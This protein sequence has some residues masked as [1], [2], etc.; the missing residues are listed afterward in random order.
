MTG[1]WLGWQIVRKFMD[2]NPKV[3]PSDLFNMDDAQII[4]NR[5][6]YKPGR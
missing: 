6:G 5:S 1:K 4:L 3:Q 2:E